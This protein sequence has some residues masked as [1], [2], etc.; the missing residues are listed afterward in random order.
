MINTPTNICN[1]FQLDRPRN[2]EV[3]C[4]TRFLPYDDPNIPPQTN[5]GEGIKKAFHE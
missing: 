5:F 4:V 3:G 1:E 2:V